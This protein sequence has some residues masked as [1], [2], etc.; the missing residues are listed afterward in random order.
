MIKG[1]GPVEG[2]QRYLILDVLRGFALLGICLANFPEFSLY[3][4]LNDE[5]AAAM[6]TASADS[7]YKYLLYVFVDGKFYTIFS[8][9]FGVGFSIILSNVTARGG[10]GTRVFYRRM[11]F[12][13]LIGL[14]HLLLLWSGDILMLYAV[15]G[16]ALPFFVGAKDRTIVIWAVAFLL[17]PVVVDFVG[18][19]VSFGIAD[20]LVDWQWM[21]CDRVGITESNFAYWLRDAATYSEMSDFLK[22]GAVERMWEF[23]ESSRYFKVM[24][25]FLIGYLIGRHRCYARLDELLPRLKKLCVIGLAVGLPLSA[26]YGWSAV[27]GRP[28]GAG[29]HSLLYFVSVYVT[30]MG[31]IA[32][33]CLIY[34][35]TREGVVW[36]MLSYPGRMALTCYIGQ[37]VAGVFIFYGI[38]RGLG[39]T[40]GLVYVGLV[41]LG[42]YMAEVAVCRVWLVAFRFGPLEWLWRCL[43]YGRLFA[44]KKKAVRK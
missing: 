22:M 39:A 15:A 11:F 40:M 25:L 4:F 21:L 1:N 44:I 10:N 16:M 13:L 26:V 18:A 29:I 38:G 37:S 36:R 5:A 32:A 9:L 28:L 7:V 27:N 41:A 17:L 23:V 3:S 12:L 43:T 42:V 33:I 30:A 6:S 8:L 35:R 2:R 14:A 24:G 31:Y 19:V 34:S 20:Q